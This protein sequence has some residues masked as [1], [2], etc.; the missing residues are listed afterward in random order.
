MNTAP[1]TRGPRAFGPS[2]S[3]LR[4]WR[5]ETAEA[6]AAL[7]RWALV[8]HL[9]DE[10]TATRLAHLER[11][12]GSDR[13]SIAFVAEVSRGKSELINALFFTDLGAR[14]LPAGA[15]LATM[16]PAEIFHDPTRPPSI[17]L[18]AIE[19]REEPR[20]LR[21]HIADSA[22]W[23]EVL[24]DTAR[25]ETLAEAFEVLSQTR[26][27]SAGDARILGL[28]ARGGETVRIP[29]WR[30]ALVNL[31]HPLLSMGLVILDTP[32]LDA[33]GT[34]P[35]LSLHRLPEAD[36]IVFLLSVDTGATP[37][38]L[39][40]WR[41]HVEPLQST[42]GERY[43]VL[44]K[45]DGLR[46]GLRP[47]AQ[48]FGEIDRLVRATAEALRV[49]PTQVFALSAKQ[50]LDARIQ[51]DGDAFAKSRLYRLEQALAGG[52]VQAR[53]ADHAA[54]VGAEA[55]A[56]LEESRALIDSRRGFVEDQVAE[57]SQLQG[58][59]QKL[60]DTLGR[61]AAEERRRI[62]EAR[63]ALV[64]LRAVHNRHADELARLLDPNG[65]REEGVKARTAVVASPFSAGIGSAVDAYFR[66]IAGRIERAI[67]VVHEVKVMMVTVNRKFAAEYGISPVEIADFST[68]RFPLELSRLEEICR[69]E[70]RSA[71]SLLTR[72]SGRLAALFFDSVALKAIHVFEIADREVRV[73]MNAFIRPLEAQVNAFQEQA[74][75]RIEGMAR[76]RNAET[77]L[78]G[79][80]GELQHFLG[81]LARLSGEWREH[82]E[83]I[84][85]L[86]E[87]PDPSLAKGAGE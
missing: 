53:R 55:R 70:L 5:R 3:G 48:V 83:R 25:P 1:S 72:G 50:G 14:L 23:Q 67:A 82:Q 11:R 32:G 41:Q 7:R 42:A 85:G 2:L 73:W 71:T 13:I 60:V 52:L 38:D 76:I 27:V 75:Y 59:N 77:D 80:M 87:P 36:A 69:R 84:L 79:R 30:Y 64:G 58:R 29:R 74:N 49:P 37:S 6:L 8:N 65:A 62:E 4:E 63:A 24:L 66:E 39:A 35:E 86:L 44:N 46:D 56:L 10:A 20:A 21:E 9:T 12:L 61:N 81:E 26:E 22:N 54:N 19:T 18:L 15:G 57:F 51:G 43:V 33:L 45:I 40:L 31:P 68:D 28:P 34:E 16:C 17:R 47:E 78:L